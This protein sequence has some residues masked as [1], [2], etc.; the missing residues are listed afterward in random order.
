MFDRDRLIETTFELDFRRQTRRELVDLRADAVD[1]VEHGRAEF[2]A[3]GDEQRA[4]RR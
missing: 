4:L 1:H 2:R 3:R